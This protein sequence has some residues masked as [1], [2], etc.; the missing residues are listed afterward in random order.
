[1][2]IAKVIFSQTKLRQLATAALL[3]AAC[4]SAP[5]AIRYVDINSA[6]PTPPYTDWATA[7][8][9]IQ[10]AVDA[11]AGGDQILVT[12]GVYQTGGK[13]VAAAGS[14][15]TNRVAVTKPL[16][17]QSVNGPEVT[18]IKGY[19]VPGI[20]NGNS[21]IRCVYLTNGANLSGFTLTGG[22]TAGDYDGGD[23][24][25][26]WC[27]SNDAV[28]TNC[29]LVGNSAFYSGGGAYQGALNHCTLSG[30][31]ASNMDL[32]GYG[33]GVYGGTLNNCSLIGNSAAVFG[34]GAAASTLNDC[35]LVANWSAEAG[36]GAMWGTLNNCTLSGNSASE[37]GGGAEKSTLNNCRLTDNSAYNGA[38]A[39]E[40]TLNNCIV[41]SNRA[42]GFGGGVNGSTLNNCILTAN[43]AFVGGGANGGKL[44]NCT[45]TGNFAGEFFG[46]GGGVRFS[47][48]NNCIV[49]FNFASDPSLENFIGG[50]FSNSCT[51]PLPSNGVGNIT[52]APLFVDQAG[53]NLRLQSN[54]PCVDAGG[55][56]YEAGSSDLDG[57][58][59]IQGGIV[60]MGAYESQ[61][62]VS[63]EFIGWLSGYGLPTDGSADSAD[64][65][66][67]LH[68]NW[69]EWIARTVPTDALSTLRL[70]TATNDASG[71]TVTWQSVGNRTYF[72]ERA[73]NLGDHP[74]FS[75]LTSNIVGQ[76]GTTSY[77]DTNTAGPSPFFYRVG[78]R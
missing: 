57:R 43:L 52:N 74:A 35:A 22:A 6:N 4:N 47:Q 20:T 38:G 29:L 31:S 63:G 62:G 44:N 12:N 75:L 71:I 64:G 54:S 32:N 76:L 67:D 37:S 65:D 17:L 13:I 40:G 42:E 77:T 78:V 36:G 61:P 28:I 50:S 26:A 30:N 8:T 73:S 41:I 39:Y 53:G 59:R 33:G 2:H 68:N 16:G 48:L 10:D 60:D 70:L 51:I 23:G 15:T 1:M 72:L 55:S 9:N 19:Q 27:E 5:A 45:V 7:A 56:A 69:Q 58:P 21:A 11:A 34:G 49:F 18:V 24:G 66:S 25:G 3:S 14:T 46:E